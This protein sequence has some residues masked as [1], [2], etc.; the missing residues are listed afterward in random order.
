MLG[1]QGAGHDKRQRELARKGESTKVKPSSLKLLTLQEEAM[2][3]GSGVTKSNGDS[4]DSGNNVLLAY[5]QAASLTLVANTKQPQT[6]T[7]K[8]GEKESEDMEMRETTPLATVTEIKPV[9]SRG[10]VEGKGE[11]EAEAR[12]VN[13]DV[14]KD[15]EEV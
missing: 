7:S 9:A 12:E 4:D 6:V 5:K 2:V 11:G 3:G 15:E 14:V 10:E 8:K 13:E 1:V